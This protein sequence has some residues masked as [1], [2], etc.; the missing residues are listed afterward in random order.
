MGMI[1]LIVFDV[2]SGEIQ[3]KV[4]SLGQFSF[5]TR[6]KVK[7]TVT[8]I[9]HELVKRLETYKFQEYVHKFNEESYK[10]FTMVQG[11]LAYVACSNFEYPGAV[12]L[13]FLEEAKDGNIEKLIEEYQDPTSKHILHQVQKEV[14]ET[15]GAL[16]KTLIAVLERDDKIEDLVAKSEHLRYETKMFFNSA[17][18]KNRCCGS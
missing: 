13:K 16:S 9:S 10:L 15:R 6:G 8:F 1:S 4:F 2:N 11:D 12:A 5:F 7:E 18:S 14:E 3:K 17:K